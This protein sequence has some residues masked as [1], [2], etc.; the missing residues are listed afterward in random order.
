[1]SLTHL[2]E[3]AES[4]MLTAPEAGKDMKQQKVSLNADG[5][6]KWYSHFGRQFGCFLQNL[7]LPYSSA[8]IL[9]SIY[10]KELKTYIHTKI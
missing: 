4:E 3:W 6:A 9:L 1:M 10:P 7:I 8:V 5:N 2:L